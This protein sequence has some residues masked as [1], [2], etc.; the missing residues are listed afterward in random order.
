MKY[1][2]TAISI[3]GLD[4]TLSAEIFP[5]SIKKNLIY[6]INN[7]HIMNSS[8]FKVLDSCFHNID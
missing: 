7:S 3:S 6:R 1:F 2:L 4:I 8:F 5:K